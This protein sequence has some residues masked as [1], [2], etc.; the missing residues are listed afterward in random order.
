MTGAGGGG[1]VWQRG[2]RGGRGRGSGE[3]DSRELY[4]PLY[5]AHNPQNFRACGGPNSTH[6]HLYTTSESYLTYFSDLARAGAFFV[7]G[8]CTRGILLIWSAA[9]H[10]RENFDGCVFIQEEFP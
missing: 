2:G 6:F 9:A 5:K 10:R 4:F 7:C 3:R 1:T 8:F